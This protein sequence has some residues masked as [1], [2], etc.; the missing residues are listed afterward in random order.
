M[1]TCLFVTADCFTVVNYKVVHVFK[2][3]F[4]VFI[5][6]NKKITKS[7]NFANYSDNA[8]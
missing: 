7:Y 2:N 8:K 5:N 1:R 4:M 3:K 6:I